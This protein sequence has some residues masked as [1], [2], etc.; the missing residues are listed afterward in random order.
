MSV[1]VSETFLIIFAAV[2]A[3]GAE[4][5]RH[6]NDAYYWVMTGGEGGERE[7]EKRRGRKVHHYLIFIIL[8][9]LVVG[10]FLVLQTIVFFSFFYWKWVE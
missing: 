3:A 9:I 6:R 2:M 8:G 10:Q 5:G 1:V 4:T 7:R